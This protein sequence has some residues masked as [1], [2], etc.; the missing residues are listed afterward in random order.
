MATPRSF[1]KYDKNFFGGLADALTFG[2][3]PISQAKLGNIKWED[4]GNYTD[5]P[6][7]TQYSYSDDDFSNYIS[8]NLTG[9]VKE[10]WDSL[11]NAE[12][13]SYLNK[14]EF[15][16]K[17][18]GGSRN[19]WG[20]GGKIYEYD[21]DLMLAQ[22]KML[23]DIGS[24]PTMEDALNDIMNGEDAIT[25]AYLDNLAEVEARQT[26]N[27]KD[28]L[29]E[30]QATF[31]NYR[32]QIL[33]NQHQQNA[34]LMGTYTSEMSKARRNALEAGA[35]AGL[36]LAENINTTLSVQNKQAQTSLETSNQLAQQLL[37]QR[38]AA[39]GIRSDYN[40]MLDNNAA[41]RRG[42]IESSANRVYNDRK[43]AWDNSFPETAFTDAYKAS[44]YRKQQ[45]Q[46]NTN[47]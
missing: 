7:A 33:S 45:S 21:T 32:S 16:R 5:H 29:A 23:N 38:Q 17:L 37:N 35:S 43:N 41:E 14:E 19:L 6:F 12:K 20:L 39:A 8:N 28:Q 10:F 30:N 34:Q 13:K 1:H 11:S 36:R 26:Q 44:V 47:K 3:N 4:I 40:T 2:V 31:D 27:F 9:D 24:M 42:Y 46:Y 18:D 15:I 22:L 25:N